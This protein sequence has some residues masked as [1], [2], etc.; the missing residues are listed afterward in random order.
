MDQSSV[1]GTKSFG[2]IAADK[3]TFVYVSYFF[4]SFQGSLVAHELA[5]LG[6]WN[7]F[8][9]LGLLPLLQ[10][11]VEAEVF[12]HDRVAAIV[13]QNLHTDMA[14]GFCGIFGVLV[15]EVPYNFL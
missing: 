5:A 8:I 6:A 7:L 14:N 11:L 1:V 4:V 2:T 3:S 12:H 9:L 13:R 15:K 10:H